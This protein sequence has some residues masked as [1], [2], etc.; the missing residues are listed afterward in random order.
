MNLP[1]RNG[2]HLG[3]RLLQHLKGRHPYW[4]W[5]I[6]TKDELQV[7]PESNTKKVNMKAILMALAMLFVLGQPAYAQVSNTPVTVSKIFT[8]EADNHLTWVNCLSFTNNTAKSIT[9]I[10]FRFSFYDAFDT[11]VDTVTADRVGD[12]APGVLIEGPDNQ[13]DF[14]TTGNSRKAENCWNHVATIGSVSAVKVDVLKVR[15]GDGTIVTLDNP[16]TFTGQY[17]GALSDRPHPDKIQCRM[18]RWP[19]KPF[20]EEMDRGNKLFAK[21]YA[22]WLHDNG[23]DNP[24]PSPSPSPTPT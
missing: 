24:S 8:F 10:K 9:A 20:S 19:W 23:Y 13:G 4:Y 7:D 18:M 22:M 21:C 3:H 15:Y 11:L 12:F 16:A 17:M 1:N 5:S 14:L 2:G 6:G